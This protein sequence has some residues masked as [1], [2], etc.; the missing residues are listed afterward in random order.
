[1]AQRITTLSDNLNETIKQEEINTNQIAMS[2]YEMAQG[3]NEQLESTIRIRDNMDMILSNSQS[4]NDTQTVHW[5]LP[6]R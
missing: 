4:I 6:E 1:M 2:V 5:N 3:A